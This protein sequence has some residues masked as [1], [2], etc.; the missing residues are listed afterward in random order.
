MIDQLAEWV[1]F[2]RALYKKTPHCHC[3]S[4]YMMNNKQELIKKLNSYPQTKKYYYHLKNRGIM[5]AAKEV[6]KDVE[7]IDEYESPPKKQLAPKWHDGTP[8]TKYVKWE[9]PAGRF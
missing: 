6:D 3:F 9:P 1:E 4:F 8:R 5:E 7:F 2:F